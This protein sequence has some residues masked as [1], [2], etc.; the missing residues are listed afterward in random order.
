MN[1][2]AV[3][4]LADLIPEGACPKR[5]IF[6][7][8][9]G[10]QADGCCEMRPEPCPFVGHPADRW[11][12][13]AVVPETIGGGYLLE[14]AASRPVVLTDFSVS[15]YDVGSIQRITERLASASDALLV[16]EHHNRPDFP[17]T[18]L[19]PL[20][21]AAGGRPMITLTC[22]DRNRLV[23]EQELAG[24]RVA[25][26]DHVLCV[27]GD[28]RAP[29]VRAEVT[30]VYDLDGPRLANLAA[31]QGLTVAVAESPEAPPIEQRPAR[32]KLKQD[33]GASL[34]ILNHV[35]DPS[36]AAA[37]VAAA[38]AI[39]VT[40]PFVASVAVY[41]DSRSADVLRRFPGLHLDPGA[42]D[43]VLSARSPRSAGVAA[44]VTEAKALLAIPGVVG[45]NL[46]GLA[47]G[48]GPETAASIKAEVGREV[49]G[50]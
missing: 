15:P 36:A 33:A 37:F 4:S 47:S 5:M 11:P 26:I 43:A 3:A 31:A 39:G 13:D 18:L 20:I 23:L 7:P 28:G 2:S 16:G 50:L 41:T 8:C 32:V 45:V 30:Q 35:S 1:A 38:Q 48:D 29:G 40:I 6:G 27:T 19:G 10:V 12:G 14:V 24:L 46:S 17:P 22:R 42:I 25:G 9:G 21:L 34:C 49:L 44:A